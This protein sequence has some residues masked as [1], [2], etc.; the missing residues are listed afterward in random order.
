MESRRAGFVHLI[1]EDN[2]KLKGI[3]ELAESNR[4]TRFN[5]FNV[6]NLTFLFTP[7]ELKSGRIPALN[8]MQNLYYD[9]YRESHRQYAELDNIRSFLSTHGYAFCIF[10]CLV[11][12][13]SEVDKTMYRAGLSQGDRA[14]IK[15]FVPADF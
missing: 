14:Y 3:P 5:E 12:I 4:G 9:Q 10:S 15:T 13:R 6:S 8:G 2:Y 1:A 11:H 7:D